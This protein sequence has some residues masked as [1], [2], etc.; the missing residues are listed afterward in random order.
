MT[1][2][3]EL[4]KTLS[5]VAQTTANKTKELAGNAKTNLAIAAE[6]RE[7]NKHFIALGEWYYESNG[8]NPDPAVAETL[9]AIEACYS[10]I[11]QLNAAAEAEVNLNADVVAFADAEEG[12][13]CPSCG[14]IVNGAFCASCG[15]KIEE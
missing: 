3:Q 7:I 8:A 13:A 14:A 11:E 12:Q 1:F 2:F 10:K 5:S 6:E 9:A 4:S 15:Q